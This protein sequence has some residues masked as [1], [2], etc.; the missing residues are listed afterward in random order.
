MNRLS[1]MM[2]VGV[3]ALVL[4]GCGTVPGFRRALAP[5][6]CQDLTVSIYFERD[7]ATITRE[8][9]AVL[10]GAGDMTR[11]CDLGHVDVTG[12]ADSTGDPDVNLELS[13]KRAQAVR[14][15]V[16]RL[17]FSMVNFTVGAVGESGATTR[18]GADRPLRRRADVTFRLQPR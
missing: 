5:N 13:R 18:S 10:K 3:A 12:L 4:S 2:T 7:S 14:L 6:L 1:T 9:R 16:E 11:G 17:G 15:A 8:A